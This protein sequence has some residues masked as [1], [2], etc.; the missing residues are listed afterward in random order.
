MFQNLVVEFSDQMRAAKNV[1][2]R[3]R[4]GGTNYV[5]KL[6]TNDQLTR[7][8]QEKWIEIT[9]TDLVIS[10]YLVNL[11]IGVTSTGFIIF[12]LCTCTLYL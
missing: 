1:K 10:V 11:V 3:N 8:D 9:R 5:V 4:G 12:N 2:H 7:T 6:L